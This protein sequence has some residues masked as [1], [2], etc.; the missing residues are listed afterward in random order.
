MKETTVSSKKIYTS[1]FLDMREDTVLTYQKNHA[2]RIVIEHSGASAL[3]PVTKEHTY[4][5]VKQYR[6]PIGAYTLEIPAGKL[7]KGEDPL[8]CALRECEEEAQVRPL[9]TRHIHSIHNCLGYSDEV[10]HLYIGYESEA[11]FNPKEKDAD[12]YFDIKSY[13]KDEIIMMMKDGRITDAKTLITLYHAFS[14][15]VQ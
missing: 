14:L 15:D 3:L 11:V 1:D 13:T 6:H 9:Y 8:A 4:I 5:L 7:N 12:E 2:T 10:I